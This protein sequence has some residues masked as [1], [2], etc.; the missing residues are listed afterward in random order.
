MSG[1]LT[2]RTEHLLTAAQR[3]ALQSGDMVTL[4][5]PMQLSL[6]GSTPE[7]TDPTAVRTAH[8]VAAVLL[9]A[10]VRN[11]ATDVST[12]D[13][14]ATCAAVKAA[15]K[16]I[17]ASYQDPA[18]VARGVCPS[19]MCLNSTDMV[20]MLRTATPSTADL[21]A[22]AADLE[23]TAASIADLIAGL[24]LRE[25]PPKTFWDSLLSA[26]A[27]ADTEADTLDDLLPRIEDYLSD[28]IPVGSLLPARV[29]HL[30][31][32]CIACFLTSIICRS[33]AT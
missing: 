24:D 19:Y 28:N 16:S 30:C 5:D 22:S 21:E 11:E 12:P 2:T 8:H 31:S 3:V 13:G 26:V 4:E 20:E 15:V 18:A 29:S 10:A 25:D 32:A 7:L 1:Q 23:D 27:N 9:L 6:A 33:C 17:T 14:C